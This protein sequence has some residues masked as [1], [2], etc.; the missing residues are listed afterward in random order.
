MQGLTLAVAIERSRA[1]EA[2]EVRVYSDTHCLYGRQKEFH[3]YGK[4]DHT[5]AICIHRNKHCHMCNKVRYLSSV[6]KSKSPK[7]QTKH[8]DGEGHS[9]VIHTM[10]VLATQWSRI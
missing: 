4:T 8:T 9:N 5:R 6:R 7:T 10:D 3:H 1:A 2:R